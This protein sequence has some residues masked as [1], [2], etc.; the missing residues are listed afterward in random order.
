MYISG[1]SWRI[2]HSVLYHKRRGYRKLIFI[3]HVVSYDAKALR[4]DHSLYF[5]KLDS[6]FF[7]FTFFYLLT[8][9]TGHLTPNENFLETFSWHFG[10]C[11]ASFF[12]LYSFFYNEGK[13]IYSRN[14]TI[15]CF[16]KNL[17]V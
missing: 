6:E 7:L 1:V 4:T 17:K 11:D 8:K 16:L 10:F 2:D 9:S 15:S 5:I 3:S 14:S 12:F 13:R